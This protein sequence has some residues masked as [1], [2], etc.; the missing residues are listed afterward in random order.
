MHMLAHSGALGL[1]AQLFLAFL[2]LLPLVQAQAQ[3]FFPSAVPL[4][5]RS[6]TLNLWLDTRSGSNPMKTWPTF[7]NDQ[8][9]MGWAGYIKVD[10]VAYHWL[11][12]PPEGNASTWISTHLTPTRTVL[13][14]EAGPML[15]NVTFLSPVEPSDWVRQ[16][17]PFSYV[18]VDGTSTDGLPH[19]I[20]IYADTTGEWVTNDFTTQVQW[21][22]QQTQNSVY[23]Q[24]APVVPKSVF[25]DVAEDAIH[26]HAVPAG[27]WVSV[28]GN[29]QTL[30]AQ[31]C[32]AGAGIT[33]KSD[34]AEQTGPVRNGAN[35]G[36][37]PVLAHVL[38]LGTTDVISGEEVVW[39]VGIVR[40]PIVTYLGD[41][42]RAYFWGEFKT[43]DDVV[44]AFVADFPAALKRANALD[45]Q[46]LHDALAVSPQY[47]DLVSLATRQ[48]LAGVEITIPAA[49]GS[50]SS[51]LSFTKDVGSSQRTNPADVLYA[52]MPALMYLNSTLIGTLL[53]PLLQF[54]A[55]SQY[56]NPYA[57]P[58][59]G[60]PYPSVPG[61]SANSVATGV[62]HSGNML[63]MVL[64]HAR[65][66]GDGSLI[67]KYY[68]LLNKW[69]T[70][71]QSNTLNLANQIPADGRFPDLGQNHG[72][73]TNLGLKGILGVRAMAEISRLAGDEG[74]A[75]IYETSANTLLQ[76][77]SATAAFTVQGGDTGTATR[78][79]WN[80]QDA[81]SFGLMYNMF[82]D[83]LLQLNLLPDIVYQ[84]ESAT[85]A[86]IP[87]HPFGVPLSS[88]GGNLA[89][90]D[91]TLFSAAS[92]QDTA[93]RDLLISGVHTHTSFNTSHGT[94]ANFYDVQTGGALGPG[95]LG[96]G[97]GSPSQG[98]MFAILAL[99][100]QNRT[101]VVPRVEPDTTTK[102]TRR[103]KAG[104]I[105]VATIGA[106]LALA[107]LS[108]LGVFVYRRRRGQRMLIDAER[109]AEPFAGTGNNMDPSPPAVPRYG[110]VYFPVQAQAFGRPTKGMP[111]A[112]IQT[113]QTVAIYPYGHIRS[114]ASEGSA[115]AA[116]S[117]TS[118][119]ASAPSTSSSSRVLPPPTPAPPPG[120]PL[121]PLPMATPDLRDEVE[122]LRREMAELRGAL[123]PP[124]MYDP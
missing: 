118:A 66:S 53:E 96:N 113:P 87:S 117:S 6:P 14:V 1:R 65:C 68:T 105:A 25:Q 52:V 5:V 21:S 31:V 67:A 81:N 110:P 20:Q 111:S 64:A 82:P 9:I 3:S 104:I 75:T 24:I 115:S 92:A 55:S 101:V 2:L 42:R 49:N 51:V 109:R 26:V 98:A 99:G 16:S 12:F 47:A 103:S 61:N 48:A 116:S 93:T 95:V 86:S 4:A 90:S 13:T 11:G 78:L 17:M 70:F 72:N 85:I 23:H 46:I 97:F 89:R 10:G 79:A 83:K 73:I 91:W 119:S 121:P 15:L 40:D 45:A 38:N 94:F 71:L 77:W 84:S 88:D 18:F 22:T 27:H 33:L 37:F 29:D 58:D 108:I 36:K 100:V 114:K 54:Q 43:L 8:H 59:L 69:A 34:L 62:E 107:A 76:S 74:N 102:T 80:E 123:P 44:D 112:P 32:K 60:T 35:G 39:A 50:S 124:P 30:R 28:I 19:S 106:L 41:K 56:T 63:V 122:G 120:L 57:A 7:W